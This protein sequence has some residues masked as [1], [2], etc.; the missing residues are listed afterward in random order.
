MEKLPCYDSYLQILKEELIPAMGCTEPIAIALAAAK[1]REALGT[2]PERCTVEVS[3]NII[4]NVKAVIV[5]NTG[6]LK[7][8][9]AS[10]SAGLVA[11]RGDLMLEVLSQ[12]TDEQIAAMR[13]FQEA[14]PISVIPSTKAH[15]LYICV[16]AEAQGHTGLCEIVDLHTNVV[17]VQRDDEILYQAA[18]VTA[19][20]GDQPARTDRTLL[21]V[22]EII[23]FADAVDPADVAETI[24][25]QIAYNTAVAE[26]GLTEDW[27]A[28]VGQT[29]LKAYGNDISVRA[30]AA[31]AAAADARMGG[32]SLP[33]ITVAGSGDQGLAAS[34]P[35]IEYAKELNASKEELYRALV[36]AS[37]LAVH[38]KTSIGRLSA[39]CG[40]VSAGCAAACGIA[41]LKGGRYDVIAH[42]ISN[43]LGIC[44]GM[45]CDGAKPACAAKI[46]SALEAGLLGYQ[47]YMNQEHQFCPGEGILG[48]DVEQTIANVGRMAA[49]GMQE[50]DREVLN[51]MV[52]R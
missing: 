18:P 9:E 48:E 45:V 20:A 25:R 8:I 32:C 1:A 35:V 6:G 22:K 27:G 14:C 30:R 44:S 3:G 37:L 51:I 16:T 5:P 19:A 23:E 13:T 38:Q 36:V 28:G 31:A 12:V 39:F 26:R 10:V 2:M 15:K 49:Q 50:T 47:M 4:K 24:D 40:A 11:G 33:V 34:L 21:N 46:S 43:T 29:L 41:Y 17:R 42:T 7:G 52:G